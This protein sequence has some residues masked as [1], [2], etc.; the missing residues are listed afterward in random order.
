MDLSF[1]VIGNA[2]GVITFVLLCAYML[3]SKHR[4]TTD[5]ALLGAAASSVIWLS[6]LSMQSLGLE[7]S[8]TFRYSVELLR[9]LSWFI[10]LYAILGISP[11]PKTLK[12]NPQLLFSSG[13]IILITVT[14]TM[15]TLQAWFDINLIDG[16]S[17][18]IL[19]VLVS[20]VGILLLEQIWR[21]AAIYT[22]A[23][24]KY[25]SLAIATILAYDFVM[26]SD[27]LL[28][29][30][31]SGALWDARGA[32]NA[33]A[34]PLIATTLIARKEKPIGIHIS[35]QMIFHTT[36]L[37]LA[38]VYLIFVSAGGYYINVFGGT[39]GE[40]L[41][42]LFIF[43]AGIFLILVLSS[44]NLRART[45]VFISKNFFDYKYDYR[46]EWIKSTESL[47]T[48]EAQ[49]NLPL[50]SAK[51][52]AAP[53]Q[54]QA[55]AIWIL[56]EDNNFSLKAQFGFQQST[57]TTVDQDSDLTHYWEDSDWIINL[58]EFLADPEKYD[59]IE[60]PESILSSEN[61]W[62][63]V[64]LKS[65]HRLFGFVFLAKPYVPMELNWENYDLLKIVAQQA[66]SNLE[67]QR[68]EEQLAQSRQFEA[69]NQTSAFLIHDIKTIIAQ[70]SLMVKN[71]PKHKH[72]PA[73]VDDMIETTRHSV[74]KMERLL[75]Q[76]RNPNQHEQIREVN[77]CDILAR[78][79]LEKKSSS[80]A[81][82]L[83][84]HEEKILVRA[85]PQQLTSVIEHITQNAIEACE[86]D[87]HVEIST[88][89]S[90]DDAFVFIQDSGSG[91]SSEFIKNELFKPFSS[92]KGL[93][94]MG[95]GA[96][97]SR[98]YLRKIGGT[99]NVTSEPNLGTCFTLSIPRI[100]LENDKTTDREALP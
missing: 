100:K 79:C 41:R 95:I 54:A 61:P 43:S 16:R 39:W 27:A 89:A 44:P 20:L 58:S 33:L 25:L 67:Q 83:S 21:N 50:R 45:M 30:H 1:S 48:K 68:S 4:R 96:Y 72:N 13:I 69:V 49:D 84:L 19:N 32:V 56:D 6:L 94:G 90:V 8:F 66:C 14:I 65:N 34:T 92:T 23:G 78:I 85:D 91:M 31:L 42:V 36:T 35:R 93:T 51:T 15:I 74:E 57:F 52:L 99:I 28:F 55:G 37:S 71:A 3:Q 77:L 97:Q 86:K 63:I 62:L 60:I 70:L 24:I 26:Y 2:T 12:I 80:P 10:V 40:A 53:V 46:E 7:V 29:N 5:K 87:G 17:L 82:T 22:R 47:Q 59:L 64:P 38:G 81:P 73:F 9:T 75:A 18:L 88:K 11:F 76:I 98:E